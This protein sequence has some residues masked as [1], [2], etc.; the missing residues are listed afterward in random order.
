MCKLSRIH[1]HCI[2]SSKYL[3]LAVVTNLNQA[4]S[5]VR[6]VENNLYEQNNQRGVAYLF[7]VFLSGSQKDKGVL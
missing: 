6:N 7:N 2:P 3:L 1:D 4:A 5:G